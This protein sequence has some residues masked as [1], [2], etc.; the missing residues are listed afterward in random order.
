MLEIKRIL[1]IILG[2]AGV[3]VGIKIGY[4]AIIMPHAFPWFNMI[5]ALFLVGAGLVLLKQALECSG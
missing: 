2:S 1:K 3:G 4:Y 5:D